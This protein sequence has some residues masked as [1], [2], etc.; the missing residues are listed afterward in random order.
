MAAFTNE[1]YVD[2]MMV[3]GRA[4]V[5]QEKREESMKSA[6]PTDAYLLETHSK[7]RTGAYVKLTMRDGPIP[8]PPRSPDFTQLDFYG[9]GR[10][11]EL[12]YATEIQNVEDLR[13]RIEAAFQKIQQ[14]MLLNTT[15]VEIR[16]RCRA[17]IANDESGNAPVIPTKLLVSMGDGEHLLFGRSHALLP[18]KSAIKNDL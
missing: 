15:T 9:W 5:T 14:E 13:E 4:E 8:W 10:A 6:F 17:C 1:E 18:V 3:Y 7:I 2:I 11:K 16:R 12:V